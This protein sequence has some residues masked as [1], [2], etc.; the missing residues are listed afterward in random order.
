[1]HDIPVP[2]DRRVWLEANA[3]RDAG[4][5]VSII[6]PRGDHTANYGHQFGK[7]DCL[8]GIKIYRYTA[9]TNAKG[10]LGYIVE[11]VYCWLITFLLSLKVLWRDGFDVIQACSPPDTYWLLGK[12]Y[13]LFG[14]KFIFDH[15]DLS[16]ELYL[17]KYEKQPDLMYKSLLWLERMTF[18]T[19]DVVISTNESYRQ[20]ALGRG[21]CQPDRVFVVR[22]GPDFDR[23][24]VLWPEPEL[25]EGRK[26][27]ICYLGTLCNQ[28][29]IDYL[30][31]A[32]KYLVEELGHTD[33]L[34]AVIGGG[35]ELEE[36]QALKSRLG[37][38]H[39]VKF[40]GRLS[41]RD[42]CRYLSSCDVCVDPLPRNAFSDRSTMNKIGE[43]MA[44]GKPIVTFD[45][46]ETRRT[47]QNA[48]IYAAPND[49]QDFARKLFLLLQQEQ[50]RRHLGAVGRRR[51]ETQL[52]WPHSIPHLLAAYR[53]VQP[54]GQSAPEPLPALAENYLASHA[55]IASYAK[56]IPK[57]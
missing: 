44:F 45:L 38:D 34:C 24:K 46:T 40:T 31:R 19:A 14:K 9:P 29:G 18:R 28:D 3:L 16:P 6:C 42:V 55:A 37:L 10:L 22:N 2:F 56:S 4:W 26:H 32:L 43:Y 30:L 51:V 5:Q 33:F 25:K 12:F 13:Q 23:L 49:E 54:N 7:Y 27:L 53:L 48:A 41:D 39:Y 8:N 17:A 15:H 11:F 57:L 36:L 47:A 50:W 35:P 21:Q 20:V 1:V 52:S